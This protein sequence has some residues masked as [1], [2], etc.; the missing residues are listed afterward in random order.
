MDSGLEILGAYQQRQLGPAKSA[1]P[2][3]HPDGHLRIQFLW[4]GSLLGDNRRAAAVAAGRCQPC[5]MAASRTTIGRRL[6]DACNGDRSKNIFR[7]EVVARRGAQLVESIASAS[8]F[9]VGSDF[10]LNGL[11]WRTNV[12]G[13]AG[14][15]N[16]IKPVMNIARRHQIPHGRFQRFVAHPVLNGSHI[17]SRTEHTRGIS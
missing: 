4:N 16:L 8:R 11:P 5:Q 6:P 12:F 14:H 10:L 7:V 1:H 2:N 3:T 17:E 9:S 15:D 13:E